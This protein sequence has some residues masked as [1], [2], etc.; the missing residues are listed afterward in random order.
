VALKREP[1]A[2]FTDEGRKKIARR[3]VWGEGKLYER[4]L[5]QKRIEVFLERYARNVEVG[6]YGD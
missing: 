3:I 6:K 5:I 2:I 4:D 1:K